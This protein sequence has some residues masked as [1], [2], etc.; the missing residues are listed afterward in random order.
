VRIGWAAASAGWWFEDLDV[1]A[2]PAGSEVMAASPTSLSI[3]LAVPAEV[4]TSANDE[5]HA[6]HRTRQTE[7]LV[8]L[9]IDAASQADQVRL[10][11]QG[12]SEAPRSDSPCCGADGV[13][14]HLGL[15]GE[16][17]ATD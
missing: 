6:G 17:A 11:V 9:Q 2:S 5:E 10:V 13:Q 4:R 15:R 16:L 3:E 14:V 8:R 1:H 12:K 7:T